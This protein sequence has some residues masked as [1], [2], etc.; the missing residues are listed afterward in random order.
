MKKF[1]VT[2]ALIAATAL[3]GVAK[4]NAGDNEKGAL[5]ILFYN[6]HCDGDVIPELAITIAEDLAKKRPAQVKAELTAFNR[7]LEKEGVDRD[8]FFVAW[9]RIMEPKFEKIYSKFR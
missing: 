2:T 7:R 9:C 8:V 6:E 5:A 4:A 1:L 3:T